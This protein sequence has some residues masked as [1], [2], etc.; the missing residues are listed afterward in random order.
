MR[1]GILW[2]REKN[3]YCPFCRVPLVNRGRYSGRVLSGG[4]ADPNAGLFLY[5]TM[6][7]C[8]CDK[9]FTP[10]PEYL[11]ETDAAGQTRRTRKAIDFDE[12]RRRLWE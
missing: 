11:T 4:S 2:D 8:G 7:C 5:D 9:G 3:P 12:A 10:E 1:F 6:F